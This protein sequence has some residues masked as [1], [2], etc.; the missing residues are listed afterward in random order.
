[1]YWYTTTLG[2]I[3]PQA[4]STVLQRDLPPLEAAV[5]AMLA[6]EPNNHES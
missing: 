4:I 3:D 6:G 1:M 5:R 2:D